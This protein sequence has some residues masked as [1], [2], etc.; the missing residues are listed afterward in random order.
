[1]SYYTLTKT[2]QFS[3]VIG[4]EY[5]IQ[6]HGDLIYKLWTFEDVKELVKKWIIERMNKEKTNL[7]ILLSNVETLMYC[8]E[9]RV[10]EEP[11]IR[12]YGEIVR[13]NIDI[14]DEEIK[15]TLIEF[16]TFL[17]VE[18][19]QYSVRFNFQGYDENISIRIS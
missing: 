12:V 19:K 10:V 7:C 14:P 16:F 9:G 11:S 6:G 17:K 4:L 13:P 8:N 15:K 5:K 18:L 3:G 2:R 1:M